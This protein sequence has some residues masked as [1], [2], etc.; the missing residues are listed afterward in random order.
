MFFFLPKNAGAHLTGHG[1]GA[2][3][4]EAAE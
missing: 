3:A 2:V 1:H 4:V